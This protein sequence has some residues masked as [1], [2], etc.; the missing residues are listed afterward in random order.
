MATPLPAPGRRA[1][2]RD[3]PPVLARLR[4][5][6]RPQPGAVPRR[7]RRSGSAGSSTSAAATSPGSPTSPSSRPGSSPP[8]P[9]SGA[10]AE[11]LWPVMAGTKWVRDVPRHG[12]D[13]GPTGRRLRR[14]SS[15]GRGARASGRR[16]VFLAVAALLGG[17]PSLWGVLAVPAAAL[18]ARP[19]SPRR[20]PRSPP[21]RRPTSRFPLIMRL[22]IVPLFLFSG[23][24]FPVDAAPGLA[25][26]ARPCLA[27]VARRR[28]VPRRDHGLDRPWAA[29]AHTAV[30]AA[31]VAAGWRWGARTFTAEAG[32]VTAPWR[33]SRTS[34]SANVLA[35]RR[36]WVIFLTGFAEPLLYLLSIGVGVGELVGDLQGRGPVRRLRDLRRARPARGGGHERRHLRHDVQL[37]RQ[38]QVRAHLRRHARHAAAHHATSRVGELAWALLRGTIYA[39]AFLV[40]MALLGLVESRWAVLRLPAAMLIGFGFAGAGHGRDDVDA[41]VRRLRL[42]QPRRRAAVPVLG[43]VLPAVAIPDRAA[44]GRAA[45]PLYQGVALERGLILGDIWT[46]RCCS[47]PPTSRRWASSGSASPA[48]V[49]AGCSCPDQRS[50]SFDCDLADL[51][52]RR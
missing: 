23:T 37:L 40:T 45:T 52:M 28:A 22:G 51:L 41:L 17:V 30:L 19:R 32:A 21:P 34:S 7:H 15:C 35:Y 10:A 5:R 42:R 4:V 29:V 49:C 1:P 9:C 48:L 46:G 38:V 43:D 18:C 31:C 26:C 2:G 3:L 20:S 12:R 14:R 36:M 8:A 47:T 50:R 44:V 33:L 13:A 11:S 39:A 16:R 27:A 6:L 24:F 25:A